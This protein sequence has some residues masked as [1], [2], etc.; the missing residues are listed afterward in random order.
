MKVRI[1]CD[2]WYPV[3]DFTERGGTEVEISEEQFHK[4]RK[5]IA[6]FNEAQ[7]ELSKLAETP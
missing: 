3:Y 6:D 2:E 7:S 1:D 4:L 5:A